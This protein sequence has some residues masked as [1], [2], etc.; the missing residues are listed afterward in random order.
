MTD[1]EAIKKVEEFVFKDREMR[2][3]VKKED[4][5][6]Y[7]IFCEENNVALLKVIALVRELRV[8]N[9]KFYYAVKN[10]DRRIKQ[11]TT[12]IENSNNNNIDLL[13]RNAQLSDKVQKLENSIDNS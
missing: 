9:T 1:N 3:D 8:E 10:R 5:N 4:W 11:L 2:Q 7:D 6:D 13:R 12:I